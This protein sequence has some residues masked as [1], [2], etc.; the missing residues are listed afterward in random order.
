MTVT[1]VTAMV[2][3]VF[4]QRVLAI[5]DGMICINLVSV[6]ITVRMR[7]ICHVP[8]ALST[9]EKYREGEQLADEWFHWRD[10]TGE[11]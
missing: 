3:T 5:S 11:F 6:N 4:S 9:H 2:L 7:F 10:L 1:I 8:Q